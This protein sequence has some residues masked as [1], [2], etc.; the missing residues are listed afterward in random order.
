MNK[1][2]K[3]TL[4]ILGSLLA[5]ILAAAFI[6]PIVFKDDIKAAIDKEIAKSVN[7]D[8]VFDVNKFDLSL[9]RNFPNITVQLGDLGVINR[10]PFEGQVLFAAERFEVDVN[11]TDILFGDQLRVKGISL[12][13]PIINIRVLEDG[14]ANWDI[15]V[16]S[17][18]TATVE[19]EAPGDFSCGSDHWESVD[20]DVSYDD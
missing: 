12:I 11:L 9:F 6:L 16:P 10:E 19:E 3:W 4:I 14:R 15:T 2:L 8:V 1:F 13:R 17:A 18:D 5:I 7:A 20:G